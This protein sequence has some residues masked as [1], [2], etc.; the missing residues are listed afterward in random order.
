MEQTLLGSQFVNARIGVPV[1][2]LKD[3][4]AMRSMNAISDGRLTLSHQ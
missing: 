4:L 2:Y 3:S 1:I